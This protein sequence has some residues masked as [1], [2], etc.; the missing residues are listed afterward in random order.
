M[1]INF[2]YALLT[3]G[4]AVIS[5]TAPFAGS[6]DKLSDLRS[7]MYDV[8]TS[9]LF[10]TESITANKVEDLDNL[11]G[12]LNHAVIEDAILNSDSELY[13]FD[14]KL[15]NIGNTDISYGYNDFMFGY[16]YDE[17]GEKLYGVTSY[18]DRMY[19]NAAGNYIEKTYGEYVIPVGE[20]KTVTLY[21][22]VP[23]GAKKADIET[24]NMENEDLAEDYRTLIGTVDL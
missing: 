23:Q 4:V 8:N 20:T 1:G 3:I 16:C 24:Y 6:S 14:I 9:G 10:R 21:F 7:E 18:N 11:P 12:F 19:E 22:F 17:N 15:A 13:Q 5:F 2:K